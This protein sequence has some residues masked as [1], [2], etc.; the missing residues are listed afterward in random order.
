[1]LDTVNDAKLAKEVAETELQRIQRSM[2]EVTSTAEKE[3]EL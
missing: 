3:K 2:V 1:M